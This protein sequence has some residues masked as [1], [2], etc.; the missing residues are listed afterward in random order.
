MVKHNNQLVNNHFRKAWD[1]RVRTWFNQP[2]RK[3]RRREQRE[4]K[5]KEIFPRPASG[6]LKP[7]VQCCTKRY[8]YLAQQLHHQRC[9]TSNRCCSH[10]QWDQS[11]LSLILLSF[12]LSLNYSGVISFINFVLAPKPDSEKDSPS[13]SLKPLD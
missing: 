2:G 11:L 3:L 13:K 8:R 5:M 4:K 12:I 6:L 1:R 7:V 10:F 9:V